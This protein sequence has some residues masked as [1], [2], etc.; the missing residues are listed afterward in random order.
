MLHQAA[1]L[2][3]RQLSGQS[4]GHKVQL[5]A[6]SVAGGQRVMALAQQPLNALVVQVWVRRSGLR[7]QVASLTAKT[8]RA[9]S[10]QRR[11]RPNTPLSGC[12]SSLLTLAR[13]WPSNSAT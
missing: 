8:A 13:V 6:D 11:R 2:W 1:A 9:R 7:S 12:V 5:R 4:G 3:L 10:K